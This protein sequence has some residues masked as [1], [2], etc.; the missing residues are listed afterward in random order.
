MS[1]YIVSQMTFTDRAVYDRYQSR[2]MGV[3]R[4]FNGRV[5]AADESPTVAEGK[6]NG[7]KIVILE[8]PDEESARRF[9]TSPEYQEIAV[10]RVKSTQSVVLYVHGFPK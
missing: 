10:D 7:E 5:L 8:F 1:C 9:A 4:K 3:F 6:W 2:F